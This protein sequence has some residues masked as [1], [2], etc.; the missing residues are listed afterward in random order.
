MT[1]QGKAWRQT[2]YA[3]YSGVD[4]EQDDCDREDDD[5]GEAKQ[6]PA[7]ND[8]MRLI[9]LNAARCRRWLARYSLLASVCLA[10]IGKR[11]F[12]L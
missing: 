11:L 5:P 1:D 3:V 4:A 8:L 9:R 7:G 10:T 2:F 6:Q 12:D